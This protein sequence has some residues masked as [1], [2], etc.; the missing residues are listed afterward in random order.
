[1]RFNYRLKVDICEESLNKSS[2]VDLERVQT[3]YV[4]HFTVQADILEHVRKF[5]L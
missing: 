4:C 2:D 1:M 3:Q 5:F